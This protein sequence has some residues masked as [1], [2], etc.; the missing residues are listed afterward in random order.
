MMGLGRSTGWRSSQLQSHL[1]Q[2]STIIYAG[3]EAN[4]GA[5]EQ[6][7][8]LF[9]TMYKVSPN[10]P[11]QQ[12]YPVSHSRGPHHPQWHKSSFWVRLPEERYMEISTPYAQSSGS[13]HL[14]HTLLGWTSIRK[15]PNSYKK[16]RETQNWFEHHTYW[17]E[18]SETDIWLTWWK[19]SLIVHRWANCPS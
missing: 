15:L 14:Q 19:M 12:M 8:N 17:S 10:L 11:I 16:K 1:R 2:C 6:Y 13:R 3:K 4:N 5:F 7:E 18:L 9:F